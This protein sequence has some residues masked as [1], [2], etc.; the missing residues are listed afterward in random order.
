[1]DGRVFG[2]QVNFLQPRQPLERRIVLASPRHF[3]SR[4][5]PLAVGVHPQPDQQL[6]IERWPPAFF[7]AAL[8]A[9][10]KSLQ[11]QSSDQRPNRPR[12]MVL[13]D[14]P[15]HIHR[16][17]THL[18]PLDLTDQRLLA[19]RIFLAHAPSIPNFILFSR[20][21]SNYLE[22]FFTASMSKS[23]FLSLAGGAANSSL[24]VQRGP[25]Q[26]SGTGE[27]GEDRSWFRFPAS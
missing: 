18:L 27:G 9:I 15:F 20:G 16:P 11:V 26:C 22:G 25:H 7:H 19:R 4:S 3:P 10:V 14:Q 17:P 23:C 2:G 21:D 24:T 1:M 6:W 12:P 13:S 8:D 5:N